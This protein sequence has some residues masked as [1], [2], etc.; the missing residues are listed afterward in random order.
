MSES[1][2]TTPPP[3]GD[4]DRGPDTYGAVISV[5]MISIAF[6]LARM[7]ARIKVI[8]IVGWDDHTIVLAQVILS[9]KLQKSLQL[10]VMKFMNILN[11][12]VQ[13]LL[14]KNGFGRHQFYLPVQNIVNVGLYFRIVEILYSVAGSVIKVSACLVLLR[15]MARATSRH[16]RWLIY[17]LMGILIVLCIATAIVILIQC[18]PIQAGWDPR[19]KGTCWSLSQ[20]LGI[21]YAHSGKSMVLSDVSLGD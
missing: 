10:T 3:G 7:Y 17:F 14:V 5:T 2:S 6:V 12:V 16:L 19:I 11:F 20:S 8:H 9:S 13:I 4:R 1:Q 21:G 15:I 18:L